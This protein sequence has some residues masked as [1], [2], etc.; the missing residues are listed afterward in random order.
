MTRK[1]RRIGRSWYEIV[2]TNAIAGFHCVGRYNW[3]LYFRK[4]EVGK[5][6][7]KTAAPD[8]HADRRSEALAAVNAVLDR[9]EKEGAKCG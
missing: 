5:A 6:A 4:R 7:S 8:Q 2:G 3:H 9:L 1:V